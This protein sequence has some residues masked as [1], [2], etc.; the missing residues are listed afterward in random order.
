MRYQLPRLSY[1][2][3]S[4]RFRAWDMLNN[5]SK[6]TLNFRVVDPMG[7][8]T[9]QTDDGEQGDPQLFDAAGRRVDGKSSASGGL[10]ISRSADGSVKK[11]MRK[12]Q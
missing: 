4:L 3:H 9:A 8:E 7:I 1:G 11:I 6:V 12:R 5:S 10:Y 2:V